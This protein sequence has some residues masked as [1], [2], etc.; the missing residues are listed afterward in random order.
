MDFLESFTNFDK[1]E[2]PTKED[3]KIAF[4]AL[5]HYVRHNRL[6]KL[7]LCRGCADMRMTYARVMQICRIQEAM[8]EEGEEWKNDQENGTTP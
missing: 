6:G 2:E 8:S 1:D 3:Y 4:D 7:C 5:H